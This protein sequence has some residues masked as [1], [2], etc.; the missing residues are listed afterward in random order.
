MSRKRYVAPPSRVI[1]SKSSS[2]PFAELGAI[3]DG[4]DLIRTPRDMTRVLTMLASAT[5][6]KTEITI[7]P[8]GID[9]LAKR[10]ARTFD[11]WLADLRVLLSRA[12]KATERDGSPGVKLRSETISHAGKPVAVTLWIEPNRVVSEETKEQLGLL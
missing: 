9:A 5:D 10:C 6:Q 8:V 12:S 4:G 3:I 2:F 7:Q 1:I 11:Y